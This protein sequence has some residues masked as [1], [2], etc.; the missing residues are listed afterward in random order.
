[1]HP[2]APARTHPHARTCARTHPRTHSSQQSIKAPTLRAAYQCQKVHFALH[3]TMPIAKIVGRKKQVQTCKLNIK[4]VAIDSMG[5]RELGAHS[6]HNWL[7]TAQAML[8]HTIHTIHTIHTYLQH[9]QPTRL[10]SL[11]ESPTRTC[12]D[13]QL[14]RGMLDWG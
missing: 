9:L 14:R 12:T 3:V 5:R 11:Q 1:M 6:N 8:V 7:H 4:V 13:E 10:R 2:H